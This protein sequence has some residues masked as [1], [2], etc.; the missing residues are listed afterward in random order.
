MF[1]D[2]FAKLIQIR[3][4][5][6]CELFQRFLPFT[7]AGWRNLNSVSIICETQFQTSLLINLS[8]SW[9]LATGHQ[10]LVKIQQIKSKLIKL[11][12]PDEK[13]GK[14]AKKIIGL[15]VNIYLVVWNSLWI[16][17]SNFVDMLKSQRQ[18]WETLQG[19][20]SLGV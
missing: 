2:I 7:A 3:K 1:F 14:M 13:F 17:L 20:S 10:K 15:K 5:L 8:K 18:K 6:E 9:Y 16:H 19:I 11:K 4:Y 12:L